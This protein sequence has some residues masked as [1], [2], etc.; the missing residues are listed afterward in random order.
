M[1]QLVLQ[2]A[3]MDTKA[4]TEMLAER[5]AYMLVKELWKEW[6]F[7]QCYDRVRALGR[8]LEAPMAPLRGSEQKVAVPFSPPPCPTDAELPALSQAVSFWGV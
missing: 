2:R 3:Q 1:H 7:V 4:A 6:C 5:G 8:T